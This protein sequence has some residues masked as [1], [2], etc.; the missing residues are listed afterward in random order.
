MNL[1]LFNQLAE[2]GAYHLHETH[3]LIAPDV[4]T[5]PGDVRN[6]ERRRQRLQGG[7]MLLGD[8]CASLWITRDQQY[9]TDNPLKQDRPI[10]TWRTDLVENTKAET[11]L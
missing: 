1:P 6:A 11:Q 4:V 9:R 2:E 5:G 8:D 10:N 3:E 7:G